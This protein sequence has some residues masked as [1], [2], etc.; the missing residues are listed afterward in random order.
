MRIRNGV[1]QLPRRV[2]EWERSCRSNTGL[3]DRKKDICGP[4]FRKIYTGH[5]PGGGAYWFVFCLFR[6]IHLPG[7]SRG[8]GLVFTQLG[9]AMQ[10]QPRERKQLRVHVRARSSETLWNPREVRRDVMMQ[11]LKRNQEMMI[12]R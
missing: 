4:A 7:H 1:K 8:D 10:I 12:R 6:H 9:F 3:M 11:K 2:D 5:G